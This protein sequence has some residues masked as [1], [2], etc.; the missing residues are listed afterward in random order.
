MLAFM[1][2]GPAQAGSTVAVAGG[3]SAG[4]IVTGAGASATGPAVAGSFQVGTNSNVGAGFAVATPAGGLSTGIGASIGNT[5]GVAGTIAGPGG[6]GLAV[7]TITNVGVGVGG[8]FTNVL[9]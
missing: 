5:H 6:T 2:I 8:G 7:G 3:A 1:A 9:P 4:H